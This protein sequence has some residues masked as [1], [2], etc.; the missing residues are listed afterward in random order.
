MYA[1]ARFFANEKAYTGVY[2]IGY[3][4][5]SGTQHHARHADGGGIDR[6]HKPGAIGAHL[7]FM[8]RPRK[9]RQIVH[10]GRVPALRGDHF[11]ELSN[12]AAVLQGVFAKAV[13]LL[14][15]GGRVPHEHHVRR[16]E[17]R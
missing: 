16:H 4:P 12:S 11:L 8:G 13:R 14:H 1:V 7:N 15:A 5:A 9:Q 3:R 10:A 6:L 17:Q 2:R